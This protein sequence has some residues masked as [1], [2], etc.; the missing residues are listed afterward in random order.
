[1]LYSKNK[2][3][4]IQKF[5]LVEDI[6]KD[7][8][9]D[10]E[11]PGILNMRLTFFDRNPPRRP[12]LVFPSES[13]MHKYYEDYLLRVYLYMARDLPAADDT[14]LADPFVILRCAGE[15]EQSKALKET[16]N[17]G[18]FQTVEMKVHIPKIGNDKFPFPSVS[19][20]V[21]DEDSWGRKDLLGRALMDLRGVQKKVEE[22]DS[23]VPYSL[24]NEP[25]WYEVYFD[26]LKEQKGFILAGFGLLKI[27]NQLRYPLMSIV[28]PTIPGTLNVVCIGIRD[29]LSAINII[30]LK[31]LSVKFDISGDTQE[32]MES[33]KH[34]V[35][36][37]SCNIVEIL[38]VP[39]D[40]PLN[41]LYSPVLSVYVYDHILGFIGTRLVGICH[42]PL[43][44]VVK[45]SLQSMLDHRRS[46]ISDKMVEDTIR[47]G[48]QVT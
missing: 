20:L 39:I 28:P 40:I 1:M 26:A 25:Q 33:N 2:D 24:Y 14:G 37:N 46:G 38:K 6:C 4:E 32:A 7:A 30:P 43:D 47:L 34:P 13:N 19:L 12:P 8:I 15:K 27:E 42:I 22:G 17:P 10:E 35:Q 3:L 9:G 44:K 11:F 48:R 16:L 45:R 31:R 36:Y 41:P 21:Y 5:T 29:L 23:L 18:W